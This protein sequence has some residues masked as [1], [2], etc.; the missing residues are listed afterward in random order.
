MRKR[1]GKAFGITQVF[2][3]SHVTL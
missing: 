2:T 3:F 1:E